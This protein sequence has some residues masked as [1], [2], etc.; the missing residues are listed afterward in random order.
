MTQMNNRLLRQSE[1]AKLIGMSEAW[2]EQC[3]F[4]KTGINFI[5]VGRSVRYR[6]I[7]IEEWLSKQVTICE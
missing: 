7:D 4:R 3:R 2:L 5:K 6:L 1:V